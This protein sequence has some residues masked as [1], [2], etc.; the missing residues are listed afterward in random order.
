[1]EKIHHHENDTAAYLKQFDA[2]NL[3]INWYILT[4][5]YF[6]LLQFNTF[7]FR[8]T[9]KP[10]VLEKNC[11]ERIVKGGSHIKVCETDTVIHI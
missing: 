10:N 2:T 3:K 9:D 11:Y 8:L 7:C 6:Y 4:P 1:M 5:E